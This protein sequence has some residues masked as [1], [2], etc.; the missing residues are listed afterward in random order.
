MKRDK[1][2]EKSFR[3]EFSCFETHF[4]ALFKLYKQRK[5]VCHHFLKVQQIDNEEL[6]ILGYEEDLSP[7]TEF[8]QT[9]IDD[10]PEQ[11]MLDS[12]FPQELSTE[13]F[14]KFS[15]HWDKKIQSEKEVRLALKRYNRH[16]QLA[17][18]IV[19]QND[20]I[21]SILEKTQKEFE[22]LQEFKVQ[23]LYNVEN[24]FILK[25]GQVTFSY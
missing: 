1:E 25:Q 20:E 10:V 5:K 13:T 6:S 21:R 22:E 8:L 14:T 17:T 12:D 9:L 15:E 24:L 11:L 23:N 18:S 19:V 7:Y 4:D 2:L 16:Q 3:K